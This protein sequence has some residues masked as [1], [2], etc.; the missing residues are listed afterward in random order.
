MA[1]RAANIPREVLLRSAGWAQRKAG[2]SR[3]EW[4]KEWD[5]AP[6]GDDPNDQAWITKGMDYYDKYYNCNFPKE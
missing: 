6:Y 3:P 5:K 1:G 4:G 2:T